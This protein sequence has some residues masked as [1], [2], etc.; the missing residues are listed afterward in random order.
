MND[1][2]AVSL[3][4]T[5]SPIGLGCVTFGR[6]ID[7]KV[8]FVM[9]DHAWSRGVNLFDTASAYGDGASEKIIGKWLA[10]RRPSDNSLL[11][12]TKILPPYTPSAI[13]RSVDQ[14]LKRL[15]VSA[16]DILYLHRWDPEI[17]LASTLET[18]HQL[19]QEGKLRMLGASNFSAA[20]L[21]RV[22]QEQMQRGLTCFRAIQNN[23]NLAVSDLTDE[24]REICLQ[25]KIVMVTYSPLGAGFLTGKYREGIPPDTRFSLIPGHQPLYFNERAFHRLTRLQA[26]AS[27][28]G[29]SPVYLALAWTL[30]QP[31]VT[32]VL[33]G[34]R[35]VDQLEQAFSALAFNDP[36]IFSELDAI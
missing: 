16:I 30:H 36:D 8:A 31:G 27:R 19:V 7:R 15:G 3:A 2:S 35:S 9:M 28:T 20:Q 6:E 32:S 33:V 12:A 10:T 23:H 13:R 34:G 14:S 18:L 4:K 22:L 21:S 17:A 11:I 25:H 24:I 1:H 26:V 5:L 29:Y